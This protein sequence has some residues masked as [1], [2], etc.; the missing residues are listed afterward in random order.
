MHSHAH[1]S[2][3]APQV[4]RTALDRRLDEIGWGLLF[5][6]TGGLWLLP[7]EQVPHGTW[8]V[9]IGVVLLALN[10]VRYLNG[11]RVRLVT[12]VLGAL[13]LAAGLADF[14]G[15]ELPLFAIMLLL[16]GGTIVLE[17][18]LRGGR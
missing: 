18:L 2:L 15:V 10:V 12:S 4:D 5:I 13:A 16:I 7:E 17:P 14:V 3:V 11:I 8:L 6:L 9:G 1:R